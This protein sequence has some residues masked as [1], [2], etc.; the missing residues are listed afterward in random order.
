M[1]W[2]L[3]FVVLGAALLPWSSARAEVLG[4]AQSVALG[5][6]P[7]R[8]VLGSGPP[9][10]ARL[11]ALPT[12]RRVFLVIRHLRATAPPGVVYDLFLGLDT[13]S[14]PLGHPNTQ[15]IGAINFFAAVPPNDTAPTISF[16]ITKNLLALSA[17][18][19]LRNDMAITIVPAGVPAADAGTVLGSV[20]LV[21]E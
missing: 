2:L 7:V 15:P 14:K 16:D 17:S 5:A 3:H 12:G 13:D 4:Q 21:L 20:E 11:K 8:V 1:R 18:N 19:G 10:A 9:V 6:N